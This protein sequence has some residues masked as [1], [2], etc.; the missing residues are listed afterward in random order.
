MSVDVTSTHAQVCPLIYSFS[1]VDVVM[2]GNNDA[3][4]RKI[5]PR[6]F[7]ISAI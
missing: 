2:H 7:R 3:R 4:F 5:P 1:S 6:H